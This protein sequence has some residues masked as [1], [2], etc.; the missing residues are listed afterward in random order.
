MNQFKNTE[1]KLFES[2]LIRFF[3]IPSS[4]VLILNEMN[5][6]QIKSLVSKS[7]EMNAI[8]FQHTT[9]TTSVK[10]VLYQNND[11]SNLEYEH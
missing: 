1:M 5:F 7:N 11:T 8:K 3:R 6:L 4:G 10:C 9:T 2:E